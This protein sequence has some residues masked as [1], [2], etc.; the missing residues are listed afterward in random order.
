MPANAPVKPAISAAVW[1]MLL[2]LSLLWGASFFFA[3]IA[4]HEVPPLFLVLFRV[5]IAALA[6]HLYLASKG[7]WASF[8]AQ[9]FLPFLLLGLLNNAIPFSL[10]FIAQTS[11]GAGLASILNAL[12]PFWTVIA[13]NRLTS[14]EKISPGKLTGILLGIFGAAVIISPGAASGL[15]APIWA[16]LAVIGAGISYAFASIYSKR[17]KGVPPAVTATG[18]LT[19][20]ALIM[21]PVAFLAHGTFDPAS[22]SAQVWA[23]ILALAL[24]STA[25]AYILF[26]RIIAAAGATIVSLVTLLVPISAVLLGALLLGERLSWNEFA[27]MALIALGLVTIDG[28]LARLVKGAGQGAIRRN[29]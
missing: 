9:P 2:A 25:L 23:V 28:R 7:E 3:R 5:A 11:L 16:Q 10:L 29:H 26:F 6:L 20:A 24:A 15:G 19:A 13:A 27:G 4:V 17:F 1:A 22:I 18:Q 12:V 8:R 14:D 21:L